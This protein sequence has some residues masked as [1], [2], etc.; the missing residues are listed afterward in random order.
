MP[1]TAAVGQSGSGGSL[2]G[3]A[4]LLQEAEIFEW[5]QEAQDTKEEVKEVV[6]VVVAGYS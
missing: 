4:T 6:V 3:A 2:L 1:V 5:P